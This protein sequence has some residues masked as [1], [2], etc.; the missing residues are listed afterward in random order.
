VSNLKQWREALEGEGQESNRFYHAEM[1][2]LLQAGETAASTPVMERSEIVCP[3]EKSDMTPCVS[4]DGRVACADDGLCVGC[5]ADPAEL[6]A[7]LV[8][9]YITL[10]RASRG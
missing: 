1:M 6:L 10:R 7:D 2:D 4:R 5:M 8:P 9:R 3:R